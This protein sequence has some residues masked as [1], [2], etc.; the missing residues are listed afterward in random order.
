MNFKQVLSPLIAGTLL[1]API[2]GQPSHAAN[3]SNSSND[4][5][6][7]TDAA[8]GTLY[9]GG[10]RTTVGNTTV[11]EIKAINDPD[12]PVGKEY[13]QRAAFKCDTNQVKGSKGWELVKSKSVG[14][15]WFDFACG[16]GGN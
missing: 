14:S 12:E 4:W 7:I 15:S 2:L 8:D 10:K 11:V 13:M 1:F 9:F 5:E 3:Q 6:F 16:T